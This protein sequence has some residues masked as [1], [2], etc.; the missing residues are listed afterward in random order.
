MA[1]ATEASKPILQRLGSISDSDAVMGIGIVI[2][3]SVMLLPMPAPMLDVFLA[4]NLGV[5]LT[6]ILTTVYVVRA[7]EFT[8]FPSLLL[9]TTLFRLSLA[10]AST[11]LVLLHGHEGTTAAGRII[12]A[13]GNFVVGGNYVVGLVMFV[14]LVIVNFMVITKGTERISEVAARFTLDAMPGKQMSIDAD[15]NTGIITETEARSRREM[16]AREAEFYGAM[17]GA[18]K[19]V[20]GDAIAGILITVINI[21]GGL[22]IGVLQNGMSLVGAMMNYTLLTVGDGLVTQ[23]PALV[24]STS[25]G[26]LVSKAASDSGMGTTFSKVFRM[27][28]RPLGI[29]GGMLIFLGILPGFPALPLFG[30]G[31]VLVAAS[32][33]LQKGSQPLDGG[34]DEEGAERDRPEEVAKLPPLPDVLEL[35]VGYGLI[36][37]V[38][39]SQA[40]DL[41]A[42]IKAIRQQLALEYGIIVPA[43][44]IRDNLQ[45]RPAEYRLLL[46]GNVV[47]RGELVLGHSL[48]LSSGEVSETVDGIPTKDPAFG[49]PA[50]WVPE[51]KN[52]KAIR[53]G[54]T[55]IDIS[56][57]L[58]T[59][60]TEL[61]KKHAD[62]LL[63]RQT[64]QQLLDHLAE[65]QPKL[66]EE[67]IPNPLTV[68]TIQKVLQNLIHE[69]VP[70]RDLQTICEALAD[71]AG[72]SRDPDILTEYVRQALARTITRPFM[73]DNGRIHILTLH[74]PLEDQLVRS[75]QKSDQGSFLALDPGFL[76]QLI[77]GVGAETR[78]LAGKGHHPVILCS[79]MVR[80]HLKKLLDRFMPEVAVISHSELGHT[81]EIQSAGMIRMDQAA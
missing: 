19:F 34:G 23:I 48:A 17:D 52:E 33:L 79:P 20:R 62:E 53:A 9:V 12:H 66:V 50:L 32:L 18:S 26:I 22:A 10:V 30:V 14:L 31:G 56:T 36:P 81:L 44:H 58:A 28:P 25:A 3:L 76:H 35:E 45:L 46:R 37:L 55:V 13:F 75:V 65:S 70:I 43:L 61:F 69:Q 38:D 8:I 74:Q 51:N 68:G 4:A 57:V 73:D 77:Q 59:H 29:T 1:V 78:R 63:D 47:A 49:L 7:V 71:H 67:L 80:R 6:I 40:G 54:Y 15:L 21:L 64:V 2:I 27:Q 39:E 16:I 24:I 5:A 60:L 72:I 41:L 11:R 42:R